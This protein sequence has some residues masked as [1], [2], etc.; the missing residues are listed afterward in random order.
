[1]REKRI[2]KIRELRGFRPLAR[3]S[4][5]KGTELK[6]GFPTCFQIRIAVSMAQAGPCPCRVE[7]GRGGP[8]RAYSGHKKSQGNTLP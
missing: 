6:V 3:Y 2:R 4:Q 5:E 1:M 8:L 7:K